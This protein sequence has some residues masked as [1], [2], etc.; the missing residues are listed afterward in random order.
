MTQ[1][2]FETKH[3]KGANLGPTSTLPPLRVGKGH[4][5]YGFKLDEDDDLLLGYGRN[6]NFQPYTNQDQYDRANDDLQWQ[7]AVLENDYLRAT[8][9]PQMGGRLWS[10]FDKTTGQ[11]IMTN[12]PVFKPGN[13]AGRDAWIAGGCEYNFGAPCHTV[14]TCD[15]L[16]VAKL[17]MPDGTPVLRMYEFERIRAMTYQMDFFLPEGSRFLFA[18]MRLFNHHREV[19]P[20]YWW[21]NMALPERPGYR[22]VVPA[23]SSFSNAYISETERGMGHVS[24]PYGHEYDATYPEGIPQA[25]DYFFDIPKDSRKYETQIGPD[26]YGFMHASTNRL[27]G[28]KLFVWGQTVGGQNWQRS[29]TSPEAENYQE[30]QAGLAQ[31]QGE[32]LPCPPTAAWEWCEAYGPIQVQGDKIHGDWA[33]AR[34]T[35]ESWLADNLPCEQLDGYVK[36][37]KLAFAKV[38]AEVVRPASRWGALENYRLSLLGQGPMSEHLDFGDMGPEQMPWKH[39]LDVGYMPTC[40]PAEP[41]VS[42]MVQT[43]YF[44]LLKTSVQGPDAANWFAWYQLAL[45]YYNREDFAAAKAAALRS[46]ELADSVW[47]LHC[48]ANCHRMLDDMSV[49]CATMRRALALRPTDLS[50]AK[51]TLRLFHENRWYKETLAV[52]ASLPT[53][54]QVVPQIQFLYANALARTGAIAPAEEILYK[55]G[56]IVIPDL[57]EGEG[58]ITDLLFFIA[59]QKAKAEGKTVTLEEIDIPPALDYRMTAIDKKKK[60]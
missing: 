59:T 14:F 60:K 20:V 13:L 15:W 37:G 55:D 22:V 58:S 8:F 25:I 56:G 43:P 26:G 17:Q 45:C 35:V 28:R 40:D 49:A 34:K 21:S 32:C 12:N 53:A 52:Y 50:L 39:L 44:E 29:L 36:D 2:R 10:L 31:T 3:I 11:D 33:V 18:R 47:G 7:S 16:H 1:L 42:Y 30:M 5:T 4:Y 48:L 57:R 19:T 38:P 6:F 54:V 27:Q 9:V 24:V 23:V 41:P 46:L 51:E